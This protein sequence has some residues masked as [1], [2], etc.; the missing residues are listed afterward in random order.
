MKFAYYPGCS[1][2]STTI[3]LDKTTR[4]LAEKLGI[5]LVELED[6]SCCGTVELRSRNEDLYRALNGRTLAMAEK[7]GL[8]ILTT[9]ATCQLS[10]AQVNKELRDD[11]SQLAK[12][13][14]ILSEID[15]KYHGGVEVRHLLWVLLEDVGAERLKKQIVKDLERLRVAPFYGCHILR[16]KEIL[17]FDNPNNPTSLET[18]IRL[19]GAEP[20]DYR[21]KT[22]CCG[23][24]NLPY[25]QKLAVK[26]SARYLKEAKDN[27][28]NCV[29]T[30]CPL[31]FTVLDGFQSLASK[32][33]NTN[34]DLPVFHLPQLLGLAM[35]MNGKELMLSRNMVSPRTILAEI[36]GT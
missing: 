15:L 20:V 9:C 35:G 25:Q 16:P 36:T 28:A 3:E 33:L 26:M 24:H 2:K 34:L 6:A 7:Q 19:C 14:R 22:K 30:P 27:G 10:L 8:N 5:E 17:G 4:K 18:M 32:E 13:N 31:C 21:G 1:P 23:F 29:V 11:K 12:T